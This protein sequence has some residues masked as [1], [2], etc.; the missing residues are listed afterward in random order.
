MP[1]SE[2]YSHE[3]PGPGSCGETCDYIYTHTNIQ[4]IHRLN[5]KAVSING[6]YREH[7]K[8]DEGNVFVMFHRLCPS[9]HRGVGQRIDRNH[10]WWDRQ[11]G[12]Y[13]SV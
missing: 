2:H 12:G 3:P 10:R 9:V 6:H 1:R 13:I 7:A 11:T 5:T 8:Y 4:E